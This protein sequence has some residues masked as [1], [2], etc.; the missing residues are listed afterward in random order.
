VLLLGWGGGGGGGGWGA[1][2]RLLGKCSRL[3]AN[4][5]CGGGGRVAPPPTPPTPHSTHHGHDRVLVLLPPG[6]VRSQRRAHVHIGNWAWVG[7]GVGVQWRD[8]GLVLV[9]VVKQPK[10]PQPQPQLRSHSKLLRKHYSKL[11]G[12]LPHCK[13]RSPNT[14]QLAPPRTPPP[15]VSPDTRMKSPL[16]RSFWSSARSASPADRQLRATTCGVLVGGCGWVGGVGGGDW[17]PVA[18]QAAVSTDD[19]ELLLAQMASCW[20]QEVQSAG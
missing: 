2:E 4:R 15:P 7:V 10:Q 8:V 13:S 5:V 12:A 14:A 18:P 9:V 19:Q 17:R 20:G 11:L 6:P 3:Q 16:M 1:W